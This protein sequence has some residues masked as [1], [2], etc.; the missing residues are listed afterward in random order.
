VA[1]LDLKPNENILFPNPY[2][3][4]EKNPLI[5]TTVR[6]LWSGDGKKQELDALK[7]TYTN[8]GNNPK[9]MPVIAL[10]FVLGLPFALFGAYRYYTM[11]NLPMEPPAEVK[12]QPTKEFSKLERDQFAANKK[13]FILGIVAGAFGAALGGGAY[14]LYKRRHVVTIAGTNRVMIIPVKDETEQDKILSMVGAA[15]TSAKSMAAVQM[16]AK[17]VK[18]PAGAAPAPPAK[19]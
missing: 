2:V 13:G 17:V 5:V 19:K 7:V 3:E 4:D 16:P 12:G 11:R 14:L 15:Q 10:L 6:I 18:P 8:K 1:K 9:L